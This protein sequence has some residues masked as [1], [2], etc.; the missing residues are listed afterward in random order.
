MEKYLDVLGF[1]LAA[2]VFSVSFLGARV[3]AH[4][5]ATAREVRER[6]WWRVRNALLHGDSVGPPALGD[7]I[8]VT[9]RT[10]DRVAK[11]S[12]IVNRLL[13]F[14]MTV[15][16]AAAIWLLLH[17]ASGPPYAYL[18]TSLVYSWWC[19]YRDRGVRCGQGWPRPAI[20]Y[21]QS[22]VGWINELAATLATEQWSA[23]GARLAALTEMYPDWALLTELRAYLDLRMKQP[24][25]GFQRVRKLV[26]AHTH[27]YLTPV[28]GTACALAADDSGAGL[29]LLDELVARKEIARHLSVLH[30]GLALSWAHIEIMAQ[31]HALSKQPVWSA[32]YPSNH[33]GTAFRK[34]PEQADGLVEESSVLD[35]KPSD[36]P[37]TADLLQLLAPGRRGRTR[38]KCEGSL[39][40]S[41]WRQRCGWFCLR[42][43]LMLALLSTICWN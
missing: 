26:G 9:R 25:E 17:G 11:L 42:M 15:V 19:C 16:Y 38:R 28:V 5:E 27:L 1:L 12:L 10:T 3:H 13:F 33:A 40:A 24:A 22:L 7:A 34:S 35:F 20:G 18:I 39:K 36:I 30:A 4:Y 41:R 43:P 6:E 31:D 21:P 8:A 37:E 32:D 2:L 14:A 23:F 29:Q